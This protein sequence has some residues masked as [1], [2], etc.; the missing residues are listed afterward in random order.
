MTRLKGELPEGSAL[1]LV[2][3]VEADLGGEEELGVF[4]APF[5]DRNELQRGALGK[6]QAGAVATDKQFI[7]NTDVSGG[8]QPRKTVAG[9]RGLRRRDVRGLSFGGMLCRAFFVFVACLFNDC[10]RLGR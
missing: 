10:G 1:G 4:P 9:K 8:D 6:T 3:F 2:V 5:A 7:A